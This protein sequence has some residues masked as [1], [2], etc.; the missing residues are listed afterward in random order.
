MTNGVI[1]HTGLVCKEFP[2]SFSSGWTDRYELQKLKT[3]T[4]FDTQCGFKA[5]NEKNPSYIS[6][7]SRIL[8]KHSLYI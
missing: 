3:K 5:F 1:K 6:L 4:K 2:T 8:E 7:F